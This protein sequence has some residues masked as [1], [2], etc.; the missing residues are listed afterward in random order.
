MLSEGGLYTAAGPFISPQTVLPALVAGLGAGNVAVGAVGVITYAGV[1]LPQAFAARHVVGARFKKPGALI[2]GALQR[3]ALLLLALSVLL[4]GAAHPSLT[5]ALVLLLFTLNQALLGIAALVW[6]DLFIKVTPLRWRGRL[7]GARNATGGAISVLGGVALT[8]MLATFPFPRG[9]ALALLAAFAL[10]L[11]SLL[12]QLWLVETEPSQ[13]MPPRPLAEFLR[14]LRSVL[15]LDRGFALFVAYTCVSYLALMPAGF[16][17]VYAIKRLGADAAAVGALTLTM[18]SVQVVSAPLCGLLAD[19][20]GNRAAL[21]VSASA[22]LGASLWAL[23]APTLSA[24]AL[25]FVL[26]GVNLGTEY[27][28]R[29]NLAAEYATEERRA[30][31]VGLMNTVLAPFCLAGLVGG[32]IC[33][34]LGY[35]AT[36]GLGVVLSLSALALLCRVREPRHSHPREGTRT[37]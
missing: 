16:Y 12:A 14:E 18:V 5:L 25:V 30:A 3:A 34:A 6:F 26:L 10:Q 36:F 20:R 32:V 22:L 21:A 15:R 35:R 19:R 13:V 29:H 17:M 4:V 37:A 24:F 28:A 23:L 31:Y 1:F 7:V 33:D 11:L 9:F 8:W 27:M 2:F